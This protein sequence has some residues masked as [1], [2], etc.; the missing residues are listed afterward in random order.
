MQIPVRLLGRP[1]RRQLLLQQ[2][3]RQQQDLAGLR[4]QLL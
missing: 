2:L 1:L 4:L 3:L